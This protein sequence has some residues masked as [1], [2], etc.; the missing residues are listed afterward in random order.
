MITMFCL[1]IVSR[2]DVIDHSVAKFNSYFM[3]RSLAFKFFDIRIKQWAF[4]LTWNQKIRVLINFEFH[5][6]LLG[7]NFNHIVF[8]I[9]SDDL[10]NNSVSIF[11]TLVMSTR[12]GLSRVMG[13][14][15]VTMRTGLT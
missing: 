12:A 8:L 13:S 4:I 7:K 1:I 14:S 11:F 9:N 2:L 5:R 10:S 3:L 6:A 15:W